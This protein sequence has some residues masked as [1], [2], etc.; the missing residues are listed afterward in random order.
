VGAVLA[1]A[2]HA[3]LPAALANAGIDAG[4]AVAAAAAPY[5]RPDGGYRFENRLRYR[6]L[7][8]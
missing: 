8:A 4:A 5:R 3:A 2:S 1:L 6:V 7:E